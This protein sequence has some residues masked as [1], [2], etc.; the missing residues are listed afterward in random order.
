MICSKENMFKEK[1]VRNTTVYKTQYITLSRKVGIS[2]LFSRDLRQIPNY[3]IFYFCCWNQ[4]SSIF[5]QQMVPCYDFTIFSPRQSRKIGSKKIIFVPH[6]EVPPFSLSWSSLG[7]QRAAGLLL[8]K[9]A[10]KFIL[11]RCNSSKCRLWKEW[12]SLLE[13]FQIKTCFL[14]EFWSPG[15]DEVLPESC[16]FS[17]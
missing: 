12:F 16:G 9:K 14:V 4:S 15:Q 13:R 5:C 11:P 17:V 6:T 1:Y 7:A 8:I 10:W 3:I 2:C